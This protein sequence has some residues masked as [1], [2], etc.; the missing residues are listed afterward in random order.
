MINGIVLSDNCLSFP[1][2]GCSDIDG[3]VAANGRQEPYIMATET[4]EALEFFIC[5]YF[6]FNIAY[7]N[8]LHPVLI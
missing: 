4:D 3:I 7:P 1:F 8:Q 6:V 5:G 2:Q